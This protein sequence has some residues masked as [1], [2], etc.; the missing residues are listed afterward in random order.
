MKKLLFDVYDHRLS[1]SHEI[2]GAANNNYCN[3][4]E[5]ILIFFVDIFR[6]RKIAEAKI[7]DLFICLRYYYDL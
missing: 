4:N 7:I 6:D 3:L 5:Y 1:N 2:N